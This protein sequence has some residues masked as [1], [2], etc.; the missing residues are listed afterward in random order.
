[1]LES[2]C[3]ILVKELQSNKVS[4]SFA[5][6]IIQHLKAMMTGFHTCSVIFRY[7]Q[8]NITAHKL[9]RFACNVETIVL[10]YGVTPKFL[11]QTIWFENTLY[12]QT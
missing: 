10:W 2:G 6:N 3:Q 9:A 8:S 1:M 12:M 4:T 5:G 7:R 11:S